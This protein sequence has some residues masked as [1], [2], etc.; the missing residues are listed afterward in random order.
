MP[1][2]TQ[3]ISLRIATGGLALVLAFPISCDGTITSGPSADP[4]PITVPGGGAR[5]A[6]AQRLGASFIARP[7][8]VGTSDRVALN[9][10]SIV[11]LADDGGSAATMTSAPG[12]YCEIDTSAPQNGYSAIRTSS[13]SSDLGVAAG[14][15]SGVA[16]FHLFALAYPI[17]AGNP[18]GIGTFMLSG[19]PGEAINGIGSTSDPHD[20]WAGVG[21]PTV[22]TPYDQALHLYELS[23]NG[24]TLLT[25]R[26]DGGV[27]A[28]AAGGTTLSSGAMGFRSWYPDPS[29]YRPP[30]TRIYWAAWFDH[31]LSSTE[32]QDVYRYVGKEFAYRPRRFFSAT[33]DSIT[34]G[35]INATNTTS[36]LE[37][38]QAQ[39]AAAGETVYILNEGVSSETTEQIAARSPSTFADRYAQGDFREEWLIIGGGTNDHASTPAESYANLAAISAAARALGVHTAMSTL[40]YLTAAEMTPATYAWRDQLN[41][42][43]RQNSCGADRIVDYYVDPLLATPTTDHF[44]DNT[45]P[46]DTALAAMAAVQRAAIQ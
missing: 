35:H 25:G 18:A 9:G 33:G 29:S 28:T 6:A 15:P 44:P 32:R 42:L 24:G 26:R 45:H 38:L 31:E 14:G 27:V 16:G 12:N 41:A 20:W 19:T 37:L 7:P 13:S 17:T 36:F 1:R 11:A 46:D 30:D 8:R 4:L 2:R 10:T 21:G 5:L 40:L 23:S 43:I 3:S 22:Q 39:Y 34:A